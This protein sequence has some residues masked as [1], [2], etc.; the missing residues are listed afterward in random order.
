MD[1]ESYKLGYNM[2]ADCMM[3]TPIESYATKYVTIE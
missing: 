3:M 2:Y 1:Y